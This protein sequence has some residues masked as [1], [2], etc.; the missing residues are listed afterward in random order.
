M[1]R[2]RVQLIDYLLVRLVHLLLAAACAAAFLVT[3]R[4]G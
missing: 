4:K 2:L 3:E 1:L